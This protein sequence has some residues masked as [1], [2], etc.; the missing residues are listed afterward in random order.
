M[1]EQADPEDSKET[2]A[3]QNPPVSDNK[4]GLLDLLIVIAKR[5]WLVLGLPFC[6]AILSAIG[7]LFAPFVWT[8]TVKILPPQQSSSTASALLSQFG[9]TLGGLANLAG[10]ALGGAR[11]NDIYTAMLKSRTM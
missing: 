3:A 2:P 4:V 8:G 9:G 6:M 10:G 1:P 5:K 11:A 7:S